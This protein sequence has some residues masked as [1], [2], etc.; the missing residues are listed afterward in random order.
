MRVILLVGLLLFAP[1]GAFLL[2]QTPP[3]RPPLELAS[4]TLPSTHHSLAH[5]A[6]YTAGG[7]IVGGWAGYVGA[8]VAWSDWRDDPGRNHQRLRFSLAKG[9]RVRA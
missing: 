1:G 8:Q 5:V 7:A 4:P 6:L 2:G 9:K 3:E